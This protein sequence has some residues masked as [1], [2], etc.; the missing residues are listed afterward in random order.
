M[1]SAALPN[2]SVTR[3]AHK[4]YIESAK[5]TGTEKEAEVGVSP[6][7]KRERT[8]PLHEGEERKLFRLLE[9]QPFPHGMPYESSE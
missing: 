5:N 8:L 2:Q 7:P 4:R 9:T 3:A 1:I 6:P